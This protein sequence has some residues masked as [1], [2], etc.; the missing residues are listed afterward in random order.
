MS[1][2]MI[3]EGGHRLQGDVYISGAKNAALPILVATLLTQEEC[4]IENVPFLEDVK[5]ILE[6]LRS[7]G[8]RVEHQDDGTVVTKVEDESAV[9]APYE[10][11][12]KMRASICTLGPLLSKR[13]RAQVSLPGGCVIGLRPIDLHLKGMKALGAE[14]EIEHGYVYASSP[15]LI[16]AEMFLGGAFGSTVLGTANVMMAATLAKGT[17]IIENAAC[18]P[19]VQD[20]AQ[21]LNKMGAKIEGAGSPRMV[22]HGVQELHGVRHKIISDRIEAGTF[23]AAAAITEGDV[24]IHNTNLSHL[25]AVADKFQSIGVKIQK[26][27]S[28]PTK[29]DIIRVRGSKTYKPCSLTTLP[30][31]GFPTDLQAQFVSILTLVPGISMVTEKVYP[32]RFMHIAELNRMGAKITKEGSTVIIE[33]V[34]SLSGAPVIASDLRASAAL[35]LAGLVSRG[36]TII[37]QIYHLDRGYDKLDNKL[38]QLG[39]HISRQ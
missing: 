39:A 3:I 1:E 27:D 15:Q 21:F 9:I 26:V 31:P 5:I 4:I 37:E 2:R 34:E 23:I 19:E 8:A 29:G 24:T 18:E 36:E 38:A 11:V 13:K 32:D 22:I 35:V 17:T 6:I 20:L 10:L 16:G 12:R 14:I 33:G 28:H 30:Y 7:L 25:L